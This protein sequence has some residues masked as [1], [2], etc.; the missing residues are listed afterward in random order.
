MS[1]TRLKLLRKCCVGRLATSNLGSVTIRLSWSLAIDHLLAVKATVEAA[2]CSLLDTTVHIF[3]A[4]RQNFT[5]S[6]VYPVIQ[7]SFACAQLS[8]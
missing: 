3:S 7:G 5:V 2:I 4:V 1:V 8:R 6:R